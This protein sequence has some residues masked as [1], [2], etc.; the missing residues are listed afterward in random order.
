MFVKRIPVLHPVDSSSREGPKGKSRPTTSLINEETE[1][2]EG[3]A[4]DQTV[5]CT[6]VHSTGVY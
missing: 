5:N 3:L 2:R 6:S 4:Q 1:T